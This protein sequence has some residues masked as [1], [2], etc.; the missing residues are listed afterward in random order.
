MSRLVLASGSPRRRQLLALLGVAFEAR[1]VAVDEAR[2]PG[3]G[4][5]TYVE[6]LARDK[7]LAAA[8]PGLVSLGADTT[9]V[10]DGQVLGKPAHPAE[11]RAMLRRL[12]GQPHE[13]V[14]GVAVAVFAGDRPTLESVVEGAVVHMRDLTDEEIDAYV[15]T[16]EP[17]DKAGSYALQEGGGVLVAEI[18]GHPSTVAGLPL[19][20]T[21][22]LL[23][24]HGIAT[25]V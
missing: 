23:Q 21:R 10:H 19:V 3:E 7:A 12:S 16:G 11:A 24:R 17:L 14:T 4:P 22:L 13:V 15:A 5:R 2:R 20:A 6:R 25:V 8:A 9:V 18:C 1:P